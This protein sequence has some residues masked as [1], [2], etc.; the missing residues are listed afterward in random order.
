MKIIEAMKRIKHL[1]TKVEDLVNKVRA[2]CAL[3]ADIAPTYE[4]QKAQV[5]EWVQ[6]ARD[7]IE[8]IARLRMAITRTNDRVLVPIKIG[9][10]EVSKPIAYWILRRRELAQMEKAV[11]GSLTD[12]GLKPVVYEDDEKRPQLHQIVRFFDVKARD[13]RLDQLR[14]EPS[15]IDAA[16]EMVNATTDIVLEE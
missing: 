12:R 15:L 1:K 13:T 7:T 10:K 9:E 16:L 5:A 4:D 14:E 3:T 8:E 11:Y 2:H 6:S